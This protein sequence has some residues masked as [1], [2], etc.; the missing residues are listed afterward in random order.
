MVIV[1]PKLK[2]ALLLASVALFFFVC[3]IIRHW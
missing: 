3:V 2:T 1:S